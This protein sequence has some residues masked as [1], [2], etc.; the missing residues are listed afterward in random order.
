VLQNKPELFNLII[1]PFVSSK[2]M[3]DIHILEIL[4]NSHNIM[5]SYYLGF[6]SS[7]SDKKNSKLR[8]FGNI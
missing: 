6:Y 4:D 3:I 1:L 5:N 8:M 7:L 2:K